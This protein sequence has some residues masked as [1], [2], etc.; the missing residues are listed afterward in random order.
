MGVARRA[1]RRLPACLK[2]GSSHPLRAKV[3]LPAEKSEFR[4]GCNPSGTLSSVQGSWKRAKRAFVS[5]LRRCP[6][7]PVFPRP[8]DPYTPGDSVLIIMGHHG[9]TAG[10]SATLGPLNQSMPKG[11]VPTPA[12]VFLAPSPC[13]CGA[14]IEPQNLHF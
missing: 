2:P 5:I 3:R 9:F 14:G 1:G 7:L 6:S 8:W 12:T 11:L 10:Q 13:F 4:P